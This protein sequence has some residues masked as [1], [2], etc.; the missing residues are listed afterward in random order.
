LPV[1]ARERRLQADGVHALL[2]PVGG[3]AQALGAQAAALH[4]VRREHGDVAR[5]AAGKVA[6]ARG[7]S[8][9]GAQRGEGENEDERKRDGG[10][11][12]HAPILGPPRTEGKVAP[13]Q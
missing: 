13:R 8:G 1:S 2:D 3:A 9:V 12:L 6:G 4:V 5:E 11:A 7:R 10:R